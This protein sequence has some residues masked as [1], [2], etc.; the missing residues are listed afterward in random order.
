MEGGGQLAQIE[1][2]EELNL[3]KDVTLYSTESLPRQYK[4]MTGSV[5]NPLNFISTEKDFEKT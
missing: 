5:T 2:L 3:L 1:S 4:W